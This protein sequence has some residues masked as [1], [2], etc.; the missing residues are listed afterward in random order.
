VENGVEPHFIGLLEQLHRSPEYPK[1]LRLQV[2]FKVLLGIPF[3]KK[4]ESILILHVLAKVVT[5]ASF[6]CPYG[7]DQ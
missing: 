5:I 1:T 3:P 2:A 6:L 7:D 4:K